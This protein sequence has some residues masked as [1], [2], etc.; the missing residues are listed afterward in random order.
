MNC[1]SSLSQELVIVTA[2]RHRSIEIRLA[3][4]RDFRNS[5]ASEVCAK[6]RIHRSTLFR[7]KKKWDATKDLS[8]KLIPGRPQKLSDEEKYALLHLYD[9]TASITN[10]QVATA[11]NFKIS[12]RSVSNYRKRANFTRKVIGDE[13]D[14]YELDGSLDEVREYC[15]RVSHIPTST[16]VYMDESFI[17]DN[18]ALRMGY[19]LRG[20]PIS[21]NRNRHGRR[22]TLYLAIREEGFVH[23]PVLST[24]N[25]DDV[26]F[27]HYVWEHLLPNLRPGETVI[28]DRLG[29]AGRCLNP[30]K[31]HYNPQIRRMIEDK[32][33]SLQ[34][35]PK[36]G[37]FFNPIELVF[38]TIKAGIRQRYPNRIRTEDELME[39]LNQICAQ[40][41][42]SHFKGFFRERGTDRAFRKHYPRRL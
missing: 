39:Q 23:L 33:C 16:R 28:W 8:D 32:G 15:N 25:A 34:M 40:M 20:K 31:Q 10:L 3:A 14:T 18:E 37:K 24:E 1:S 2:N 35:L 22:W 19:S 6:Y 17:Y 12:P 26:N 41:R 11:I 42:A 9:D 4:V 38:G 29:K 13:H 21:R 36:R 7:W 5:P 27:F 30:I